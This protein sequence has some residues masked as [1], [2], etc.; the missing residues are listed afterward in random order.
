MRAEARS[1]T[2]THRIVVPVA[3]FGFILR[4]PPVRRSCAG[5]WFQSPALQS[6]AE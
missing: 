1:H 4:Q 2:H 6:L 3:L 5:D